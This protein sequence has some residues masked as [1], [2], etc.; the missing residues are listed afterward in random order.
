MRL[1]IICILTAVLSTGCASVLSPYEDEFQCP[2]TY[3][4][5][6]TSMQNAY[7]ES[8]NNVDSRAAAE[9]AEACGEKDEACRKQ[10]ALF[11]SRQHGRSRAQ[12]LFQDR[13]FKKLTTLIEDP[14][15]PVLIPPEVVRVLI[16][17]YTTDT[18]TCLGHRF[19][20]F[21]ATDPKFILS[22]NSY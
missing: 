7:D 14:V 17:S 4:G 2:D 5:R 3:K 13:Q 21:L 9:I 12:R 22:P 15:T 8:V 10:Y 18:N 11:V 19:G 16:L 20:Y 6:C 1:Y